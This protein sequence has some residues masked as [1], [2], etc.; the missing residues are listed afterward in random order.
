MPVAAKPNAYRYFD[1]YGQA[2]RAYFGHRI[3]RR[4]SASTM[5]SSVSNGAVPRSAA[6]ASTVR[7]FS[8]S[9]AAE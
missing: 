4:S 6:T 1:P 7:P 8:P 3:V 5:S 2:I 9:F